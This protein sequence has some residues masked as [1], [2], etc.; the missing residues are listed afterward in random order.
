[1]EARRAQG[2]LDEE[3]LLGDVAT[4]QR[5]VGNSVARMAALAMGVAFRKAYN[6]SVTGQN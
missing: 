5:I 4:Q 1:M 3:V 6:A 2:F